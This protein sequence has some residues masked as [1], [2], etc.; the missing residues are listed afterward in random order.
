[1]TTATS[2]KPTTIRRFIRALDT[3]AGTVV[4]ETDQ[5]EGYLK[6]LGNPAGPH[7]LA[8]DWIGTSLA[9]RLSL[10]TFAFAIVEVTTEDEIPLARGG[11]AQPGP[12]FITRSE[13][14]I[15][16]GGTLREL[17]R[18]A[19][20]ED[21]T[22]LVLFDTWLRNCDRHPLDPT[23]R[24]P[25]RDNVFFSRDNA[26]WGRFLLKVM[27][28]T[29][30][31]TCG[32]DLTPR[33]AEIGFIR[34]EGC[35][36]LFPEFLPFLDRDVMRGAVRTLQGVGREEVREVLDAIPRAW[37][38]SSATRDALLEFLCRRAAFVA[39]NI[40][41]WIWPQREFDFPPQEGESP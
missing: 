23:T 37:E 4:V 26:P 11:R 22:P 25:N 10:L 12:A 24:R 40:E 21:I 29:H 16:W 7:A 15:T 6:A 3:G 8:C 27:D 30:C 28:H 32:R 36:G 35:Y 9:R 18:L 5:G 20:P 13:R 2:W 34:E 1:M 33:I 39:D 19:N 41:A 38:I 14:G 31:L 17:R